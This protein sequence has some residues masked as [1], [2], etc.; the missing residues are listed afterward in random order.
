LA[1]RR[2]WPE[3]LDRYPLRIS[4][5]EAIA[6]IH[7]RAISFASHAAAAILARVCFFAAKGILVD[8]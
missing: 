6:P 3:S 1:F 5:G 7:D 2:K 8:G 4:T